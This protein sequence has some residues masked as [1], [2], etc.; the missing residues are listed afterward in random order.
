MQGPLHNDLHNYLKVI[1]G[2]GR[3]PVRLGALMIRPAEAGG[4]QAKTLSSA[5][6]IASIL[7]VRKHRTAKSS[8]PIT[9]Y[10]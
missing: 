4:A 1:A 2:G 9:E 7:H 6:R 10:S 3:R 5:L 8:T